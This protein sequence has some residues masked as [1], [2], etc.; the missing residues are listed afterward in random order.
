MTIS[1]ESD[2]IDNKYRRWYFDILAKGSDTADYTERHHIIPKSLGGRPRAKNN[3]IRVTAR[4]HFLL[5]W[6]L[7]K[8]TRGLALRKMQHALGYM[9][10]QHE[11][12]RKLSSWQYEL[13]KQANRIAAKTR[14]NEYWSDPENREVR[15][16]QVKKRYEDPREREKTGMLTRQRFEDPLEVEKSKRSS[17]KRYAT[18]EA[19]EIQRRGQLKRYQD[20]QEHEKSKYLASKAWARRQGKIPEDRTP[21]QIL[22]REYQNA[23][24]R[25]RRA[26]KHL[27]EAA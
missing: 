18:L 21:E 7:T 11:D 24:Q 22:K 2:F 17:K 16:T 26:A 20:P 6:L 14:S 13:S 27:K 8:F 25:A 12:E 3:L 5:H 1:A 4:K 9:A 10:M 19:H 15:S 23:S